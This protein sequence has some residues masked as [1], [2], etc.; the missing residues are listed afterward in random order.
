M[1]ALL[2]RHLL[3][4]LSLVFLVFLSSYG[5]ADL[6]AIKT[7]Y[8]L[9]EQPS[10]S[11]TP[12]Y[13]VAMD[14]YELLNQKFSQTHYNTPDTTDAT[15]GTRYRS[16]GNAKDERSW[17]PSSG[18][19]FVRASDISLGVQGRVIREKAVA[20]DIAVKF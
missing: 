15:V 11:D 5:Y 20:A 12:R 13:D 6:A 1:K 14:Q 10:Y 19:V 16:D 7:P 17:E 9:T 8:I 18:L 4:F 3:S 2:L